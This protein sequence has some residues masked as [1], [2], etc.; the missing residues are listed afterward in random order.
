MLC[1]WVLELGRGV[2]LIN[3]V[4]DLYRMKLNCF[5]NEFFFFMVY[6]AEKFVSTMSILKLIQVDQ[7]LFCLDQ[8]LCDRGQG[9]A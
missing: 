3:I 1:L 9:N 8:F 5:L 6:V 2:Y 4:V 7:S